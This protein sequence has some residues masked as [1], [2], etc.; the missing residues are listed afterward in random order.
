MENVSSQEESSWKQDDQDI[1]FHKYPA[2]QVFP[3]M[4][5]PYIEGPKMDWTMNDGLYSR[6]LKWKLKCKNILQCELAVL[7]EKRKCKK[8]IVWSGDLGIDQYVS[9]NLTNEELTVDVI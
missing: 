9:W 7:V 5:I 4:F 3:S 1:T 2:Q 8:I 6:F